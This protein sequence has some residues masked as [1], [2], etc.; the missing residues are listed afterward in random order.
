MR[1][2][3]TVT[4]IREW[5]SPRL[6]VKRTGNPGQAT[7]S[8][9]QEEH[10]HGGWMLL[11]TAMPWICQSVVEHINALCVVYISYDTHEGLLTSDISQIVDT[12]R[13]AWFAMRM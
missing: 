10:L 3:Q 1:G 8:I 11:C 9:L 7:L 4:D 2:V 13:N 12:V 5:Q 6:H